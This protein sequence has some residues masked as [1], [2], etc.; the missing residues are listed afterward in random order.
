MMMPGESASNRSGGSKCEIADGCENS[1]TMG[2]LG[3][4]PPMVPRAS[5]QCARSAPGSRNDPLVFVVR[6]HRVQHGGLQYR[7]THVRRLAEHLAARILHHSLQC[8]L[9]PIDGR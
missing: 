6:V 7:E 5:A 3:T 8:V 2:H 1:V 9:A 4:C